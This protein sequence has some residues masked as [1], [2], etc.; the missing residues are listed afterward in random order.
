M[1]RKIALMLLLLRLLLILLRILPVKM[2]KLLGP[3]A[4]VALV[5]MNPEM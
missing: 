5:S 2:W 3:L 4:S 1:L